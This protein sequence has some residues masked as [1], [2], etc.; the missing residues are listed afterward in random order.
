M[1]AS[2][3]KVSLL[4]LAVAVVASGQAIKPAGTRMMPTD[5]HEAGQ[6]VV[7]RTTHR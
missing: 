1:R 7:P 6:E 3:F 5:T 2:I 4:I